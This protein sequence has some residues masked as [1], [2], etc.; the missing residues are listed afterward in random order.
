MGLA[1]LDECGRIV[2]EGDED[3]LLVEWLRSELEGEFVCGVDDV[4][5]D[6]VEVAV[7]ADGGVDQGGP[8]CVSNRLHFTHSD[9]R[10]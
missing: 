9:R 1:V 7:V 10:W 8:V 2:A 5:V 6:E 3:G 4:L